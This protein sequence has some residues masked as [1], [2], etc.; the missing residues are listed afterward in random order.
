MSNRILKQMRKAAGISCMGALLSCTGSPQEIPSVTL[1]GGVEMPV[2]G[3]G[4]YTLTGDTA[5]VAVKNALQLGYRH[6]DARRPTVTRRRFT[7]ASG[8]AD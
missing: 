5:I 4:T 7:K 8:R 2:L 3:L 1:T 6:I